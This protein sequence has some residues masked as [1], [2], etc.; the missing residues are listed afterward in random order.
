MKKLFSIVLVAA[1]MLMSANAN[2]VVVND[3]QSLRD[4]IYNALPGATV[5]IELS[6]DIALTDPINIFVGENE[7]GK[8]ITID[9]KNFNITSTDWNV[10]NLF[11]GKLTV[12]GDG[13]II[14]TKV[15][16]AIWTSVC[17]NVFGHYSPEAEDWSVLTI[18]GNVDVQANGGQGSRGV[19]IYQSQDS[20]FKA[21]NGI[22][23]VK[24]ALYNADPSLN[25]FWT[26]YKKDANIYEKY[27]GDKDCVS[28]AFGV[29]VNLEDS[30]KV[31]GFEYGV[32][33]T[34][35]VRDTR[36]NVPEIT[37]GKGVTVS[38]SA[39]NTKSAAVYS[40]GYG[41]WDIQGTIEGNTGVYAK[42]GD[43]TLDG[44][45]V[46]STN[47]EYTEVTQQGGTGARGS[48][49]QA[50][51]S[52]VV[53]E[54]NNAYAGGISLDVKGDTKLE[55]TSG[56][57]IEG[58]VTS[59]T[60]DQFADVTVESG[61]IT[62]GNAGVLN[63][64]ADVAEEVKQTGSIQGGTFNGD[65]TEYLSDETGVITQAEDE[66]GNIIYT[67]TAKE[68][69]QEFVTNLLTAGENDMVEV[70]ED[71]TLT[72]DVKVKYVAIKAGRKVTIPQGIAMEA[73]EVVLGS[74]TSVIDVQAG[75]KLIVSG[76]QGII[77]NNAA[78][79]VLGAEEGNQAILLLNPAV[80]ANKTP[81]ATVNF[82]SKAWRNDA[83]NKV[84]QFFGVPF[85]EVTRF[86]HAE[87]TTYATNLFELGS[88]AVIASINGSTPM[89]LSLFNKPYAI[90]YMLSNNPSTTLPDNPM[91]YVLAGKL[92]GNTSPDVP[93]QTQ[94]SPLA[95][96]YTGEVDVTA[97]IDRLLGIYTTEENSIDAAIYT[98]KMVG[99]QKIAWEAQN[100]IQST[101]DKV[102]PMQP[103]MLYKNGAAT[104]FGMSYSDF[105]WA[106]AMGTNAP[107]RVAI[108]D[109]TRATLNISNQYGAKDILTIAEAD[110]FSAAFDNG[111]DARKYM[112]EGLNLYANGAEKMAV[113]A[114]NDVNNTYLG[115]VADEAGVYTINFSNVQGEGLTLIDLV[116]NTK[117]AIVEGAEY[118]FEAKAGETVDHRFAIESA[119]KVATNVENAAVQNDIVKTIVNDQVVIIR[120]G[121]RYNTVGQRL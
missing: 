43:I 44:A 79:I 25:K 50:G 29:V 110:E 2:A 37:I 78:N 91:K 111:Y 115:F 81:R 46:R 61:T 16:D 89:D 116:N 77:S 84:Y 18:Q 21:A 121:V 114:S 69:G 73:G 71:V 62:G 60:P 98:Y 41:I 22:L 45:T 1:G 97:L 8:D 19:E 94:W 55:A 48:G 86:E 36:G 57:A 95:N 67:I 58:V 52:A 24:N 26:S 99:A 112:N 108:Q 49:V 101:I 28:H 20:Y 85:S 105:V 118:Q 27:D 35:S 63:L 66:D 75:G 88:T 7:A 53:L 96:S 17:F 9:L 13:K 102:E 3:E 117:I 59:G 51:G 6:G 76:T 104:T 15:K 65:I 11:K 47:T 40:G 93:V 120:N 119:K 80:Q 109:I 38:C 14:N 39:T 113:V 87:A 100:L 72:A 90:Y 12:K 34:G 4:A 31:Y 103:I 107:R 23:E 74:A 92:I 33:I 56:Y 64:N 68:P 82:I 30:V 83:S 32:Q 5:N 54:G 10:F 106:P 42:A 70:D